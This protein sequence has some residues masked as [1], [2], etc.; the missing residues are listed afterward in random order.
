[1]FKGCYWSIFI[2]AT[3]YYAINGQRIEMA[4]SERNTNTSKIQISFK[5]HTLNKNF[6]EKYCYKM[7]IY[8]ANIK[9]SFQCKDYNRNM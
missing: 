4:I 8:N 7:K 2:L 3:A 6:N 1:M 5:T 9:K